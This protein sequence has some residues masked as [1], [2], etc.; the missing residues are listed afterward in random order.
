[1]RRTSQSSPQSGFNSYLKEYKIKG[2]DYV[3]GVVE[4]R[5]AP[6]VNRS[7]SSRPE[8]TLRVNNGT[9]KKLIPILNVFFTALGLDLEGCPILINRDKGL[10]SISRV[11]PS[12][13]GDGV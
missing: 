7:S 10:E 11:L 5:E 4:G 6:E 3:S 1:L 9:Y 13:K 12:E 8:I 2:V